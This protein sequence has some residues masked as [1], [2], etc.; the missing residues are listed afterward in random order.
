MS[1]GRQAA[2]PALDI[3]GG[4]GS[5]VNGAYK[6]GGE[7]RRQADPA[8]RK[9]KPKAKGKSTPKAESLKRPVGRKK[10]SFAKDG[11]VEEFMRRYP[12]FKAA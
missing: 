6:R 3:T 8:A 2:A 7:V 11:A 9:P 1:T 5:T 10:F 4:V 12:D